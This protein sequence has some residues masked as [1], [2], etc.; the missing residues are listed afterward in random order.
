[1]VTAYEWLLIFRFGI[2]WGWFF[3]RWGKTQSLW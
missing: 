2:N 1:M 3:F